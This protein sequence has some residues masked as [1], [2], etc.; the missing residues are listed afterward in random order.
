MFNGDREIN[1]VRLEE[2]LPKY[3][4]WT[5][6]LFYCYLRGCNCEGCPMAD[7]LKS[8]EV[9]RI[10]GLKTIVIN[11]IKRGIKPPYAAIDPYENED[12]DM[13]PDTAEDRYTRSIFGSFKILNKYKKAQDEVFRCQNCDHLVVKNAEKRRYYKCAL[14]G[15]TN[16][17][18]SD[19][20]LSYVCKK[21]K[22][23]GQDE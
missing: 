11:L 12:E 15:A 5:K 14:M 8:F 6:D 23:R 20:R 17:N 4:Y 18:V 7:M 16:S 10:C 13:Q 19:I 1:R 21:F 9:L 2:E 22:Q 3:S